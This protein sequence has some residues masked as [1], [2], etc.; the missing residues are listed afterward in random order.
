MDESN[1]AELQPFEHVEDAADALRVAVDGVRVVLVGPKGDWDLLARWALT[2]TDFT[3]RAGVIYNQLQLHALAG[4]GQTR[5]HWT[6]ENKS[7][8][9]Q[10][11]R[12]LL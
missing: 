6:N 8:P 1:S 10:S 12:L 4:L 3:L 5:V 2:V 11:T 9:R 7:Q